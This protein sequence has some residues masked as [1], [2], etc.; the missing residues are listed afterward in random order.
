MINEMNYLIVCKSIFQENVGSGM[1]AKGEGIMDIEDNLFEK[2]QGN[3]ARISNCKKLKFVSNKSIDNHVDGAEFINCNGVIMLNYFY[4]NRG[5]GV[6][7]STEEPESRYENMILNKVLLL[8]LQRTQV[9]RM[10]DTE[11]VLKE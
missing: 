11:S 9:L 7:L 8:N 10:E 1:Y 4:K 5:N 6:S 2:T 3:G